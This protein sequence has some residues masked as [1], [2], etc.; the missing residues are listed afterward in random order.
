MG[1]CG[2]FNPK[3]PVIPPPLPKYTLPKLLVFE[4]KKVYNFDYFTVKERAYFFDLAKHAPKS[5]L[6]FKKANLY[7]IVGSK[8]MR[9]AEIE[10]NGV[11][12]KAQIP[13]YIDKFYKIHNQVN[14][15]ALS[16][17]LYDISAAAN[18]NYAPYCSG[19]GNV[20][21]ITES[22]GGTVNLN[23]LG[24]TVLV[25]SSTALTDVYIGYDNSS[26]SYTAVSE[27]L[28]AII[29]LAPRNCSIGNIASASLSFTKSSNQGVTFIWALTQDVSGLN[30]N[31]SQMNLGYLFVAPYGTCSGMPAGWS[32]TVYNTGGGTQGCTDTGNFMI[33]LGGTLYLL[34]WCI[35]DSSASYTVGSIQSV[36]V[37]QGYCSGCPYTCPF[38]PVNIVWSTPPNSPGSKSPYGPA[39]W[40]NALTLVA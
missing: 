4:N 3:L 11:R 6:G 31:L 18:Y 38:P 12:V 19:G 29:Q 35:D 27:S 16:Q 8:E 40:Y 7:V 24:P 33:T 39:T 23:V 36:A 32:I 25:N 20:I 34:Y 10:I 37:N 21:T 30:A 13:K 26:N 9:T 14:Q 5:N 2:K 17:L 15:S 1:E 28:S 22:G